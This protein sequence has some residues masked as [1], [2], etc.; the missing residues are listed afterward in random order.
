MKD[1]NSMKNWYIPIE[2]ISLKKLIFAAFIINLLLLTIDYIRGDSEILIAGIIGCALIGILYFT[3]P[4]AAQAQNRDNSLILSSVIFG[5]GIYKLISIKFTLF[6]L[7]LNS[8]LLIP[9]FI[10][11]LWL[12]SRPVTAWTSNDLPI[13]AIEYGL[14]RNHILGKKHR[15]VYSHVTLIHFSMIHSNTSLHK[16]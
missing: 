6:N 9:S 1:N 13:S 5:I 14:E 12:S 2:I 11:L 8:W 7:W 16:H 10:S 4:S 3:I 15:S